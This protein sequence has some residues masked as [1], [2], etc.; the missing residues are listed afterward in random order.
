IH[1]GCARGASRLLLLQLEDLQLLAEPVNIPG[2]W[3]EYP[4]WRRK[5][6]QLTT[7]IF[8][9]PDVQALLAAVDRE[10]RA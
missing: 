1:Q 10:R 3:R 6:A 9:A 4:N 7:A 5:Q 8:A 2:T